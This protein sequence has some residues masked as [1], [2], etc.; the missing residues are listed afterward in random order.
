[1]SKKLSARSPTDALAARRA[2]H[3]REAGVARLGDLGQR[4]EGRLR[5]EEDH[6]VAFGEPVW[7]LEAGTRRD[8]GIGPE[9]RDAH[10]AP[11]GPK[12]QPW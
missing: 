11:S 7:R 5:G 8:G 2:R 9:G 6:A 10:A 12:R 1:M 3:R 4:H